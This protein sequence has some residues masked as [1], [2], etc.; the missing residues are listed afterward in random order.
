MFQVLLVDDEPSVRSGMKKL[1]D[2]KQFGFELQDTAC[3]GVEACKLQKNKRYDLIITDLKMPAMDGLTLIQTLRQEGYEGE[4]MILSAYGE[5]EYAR[6]AMQYGVRYYLLKPVDDTLLLQY[7]Q[8]LRSR[9]QKDPEANTSEEEIDTVQRVKQYT[10][11]NYQENL[12]LNVVAGEM[13]FNPGYLGRLFK[14]SEGMSY[15]E[16]LN[17]VRIERAKQLLQ[18][19]SKKIF[20]IAAQVGYQDESYFNRCFKR[21]EGITPTEY[22]ARQENSTE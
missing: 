21:M 5:F 17:Q 1:I 7:L 22:R 6:K 13:N 18:S 4:F 11:A 9:L 3:N 16:Y 19:G 14:H 12:S 10:I 8:D 15:N 20:E 2:W